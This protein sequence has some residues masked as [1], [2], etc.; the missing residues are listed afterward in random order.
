MSYLIALLILFLA[1]IKRRAMIL[2]LPIVPLFLSKGML[3]LDVPQL[4]VLSLYRFYIL[5]LMGSSILMFVQRPRAVYRSGAL[6]TPLIILFFAHI[7]VVM[8]NIANSNSGGI[9]ALSFFVDVLVP[10]VLLTSFIAPLCYQELGVLLKRYFQVYFF[11]AVLGIVFFVVGVNPFVELMESTIS[12]DRVEVHTYENTLRGLRAQGTV[13]HP[14]NFGALMVFGSFLALMCGGLRLIR[15]GTMFTALGIFVIA[16]I[17]TSSR[18][19]M[20]FMFI[21]LFVLSLYLRPSRTTLM[22]IVSAA[23]IT[24]TVATSD[25]VADRFASLLAL[26]NADSDYDAYGSTV[27]MRALQLQVALDNF[28]EAPIFGNGLGFTRALVGAETE[29]D[30]KNSESL[31]FVVL[32][33]FGL[34]GIFAFVFLFFQQLS[35]VGRDVKHQYFRGLII[36]LVLGYLSFVLSTGVME[37]LYTYLFVFVAAYFAVLKKKDFDGG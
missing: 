34:L 10:T 8:A 20:I 26:L 11:A 3:L 2:S 16:V 5:C 31:A 37:T 33:D 14:M 27:E 9:V 24:I 25:F 15:Q 32:M 19:P 17:M 18:S 1:V 23:L 35:L 30:L 21:M 13:Y 36:G 7:F 12:T 4:P 28:F 6:A 22:Y 29:L